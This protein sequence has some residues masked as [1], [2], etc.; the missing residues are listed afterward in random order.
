MKK[1]S[2]WE[3]AA[4]FSKVGLFTLGGG[5]AMIPL[6][7]RE[8]VQKRKWME[9]DEF[10]DILSIA[11]SS[12]GLLA[13]NISIFAG[14]RMRGRIGSVAAAIG[15]ALPSFLIILAIALFFAG[16]RDNV[17]VDKIFKGIRP[18]V[19]ALIAV[20]VV[21]MI[22]RS[23][24]N[25]WRAIVAVATAALIIFLKVSPIYILL[26]FFAC[27]FCARYVQQRNR[28]QQKGSEHNEKEGDV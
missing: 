12:P 19:V 15:T 28:Q 25:I 14:Y 13:V 11:Q 26:V 24:L 10:Y 17:Y 22:Q 16:Y 7:D 27:F 2:L 1:V 20:P 6:I 9:A 21:D 8:V 23:H 4:V 18:V 5:Y 3:L